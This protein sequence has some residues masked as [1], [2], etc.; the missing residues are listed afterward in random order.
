[1]GSPKTGIMK[2]LLFLFALLLPFCSLAQIQEATLLGT[3][4]DTTLVGSSFYD[5]TYNEIWGFAK[6]GREYAILG[7]T[8]GTHIIE[9]TNPGAPAEAFFIPGA[10]Q[11]GQVIHRDYHDL[12]GFLYAVCDEGSSTLQIINLN[13]LPEAAPVIY[14]SQET[15][16]NAHNIF[17]DEPAKRLY[18]FAAFGGEEGYSAMRIYD[19]SDPY[20]LVFLAEH[21]N[22]GG[23]IAG[24]VHDG[25]VRNHLAFLNCGNAG[26]AIVDFTDPQYPVTL[27]TLT[28][29]PF[30][31]YNHSG[32]TT[33]DCSFYYMADENH[34]YNM[35]VIDVSNPCEAEVVASFDAGVTSPSSIPHNQIVACGYLY[36]SYY[37][38]GLRIYDLS[39]PEHPELVSYYDT[40]P[41]ADGVSY[42]GAWG[43]YP[44]LPSGNILVSDMQSGLF[45]FEG[46]GDNCY[47]NQVISDCNISCMITAAD[48]ENHFPDINIF[49]QPAKDHLNVNI[50]LTEAQKSVKFH[51]YDITGR[52]VMRFPERD[53]LEG[54]NQMELNLDRKIAPGFYLLYLNNN[55][56]EAGTKVIIGQ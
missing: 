7:S 22:F 56:F 14:D 44:F 31:G 53:L 13:E 38:D 45:V 43:I 11:G 35:K 32:W 25:Y 4:D 6:S 51:I 41:L 3:W 8:A 39:D 19:I 30:A 54:E 37:Y 5:N 50:N 18:C 28:N 20:Q 9:V 2:K 55:T 48:E 15:L 17:I 46:M 16:R 23:L 1:M 34:G 42:K 33:D 21:N 10:V 12:N 47:G 52:L 27:N 29:Y 40:Y 49:P 24:H 36:V 26:F